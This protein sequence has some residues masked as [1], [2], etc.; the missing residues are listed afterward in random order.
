[1]LLLA[2]PVLVERGGGHRQRGFREREAMGD[3]FGGDEARIDTGH[4]A[5]LDL[6]L[7]AGGLL[8]ER[9]GLGWRHSLRLCAFAG[10]LGGVC[11]IGAEQFGS[12]LAP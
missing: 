5:G 8:Q 6:V 2:Q 7:A 3:R 12:E 11:R 1:M 9:R 4:T 10:A